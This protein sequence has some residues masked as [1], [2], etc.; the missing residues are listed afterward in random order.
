MPLDERQLSLYS[1]TINLLKIFYKKSMFVKALHYKTSLLL[2]IVLFT[3]LVILV[4]RFT[5]QMLTSKIMRCFM[6][7]DV[8]R[9]GGIADFA[10]F[11]NLSGQALGSE[12]RDNFKKGVGRVNL[13]WSWE[14]LSRTLTRTSHGVPR[15]RDKPSRSRSDT[16]CT[17]R[18]CSRRLSRSQNGIAGIPT[19]SGW[20]GIDGEMAVFR[21]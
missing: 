5:I 4:T 3:N 16:V 9:T 1:S 17:P 14:G 12:S 19:H 11:L 15:A 10:L 20:E 6:R 18:D 8:K 13:V 2:K 21:W 7:Q